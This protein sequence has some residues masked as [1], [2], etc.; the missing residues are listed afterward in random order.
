MPTI[1]VLLILAALLLLWSALRNAPFE[2]P[3]CGRVIEVY[4]RCPHCG[5]QMDD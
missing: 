4:N 3:R 2:C 1:V 5:W